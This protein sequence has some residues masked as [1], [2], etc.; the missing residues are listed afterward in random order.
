MCVGGVVGPLLHPL[1]IALYSFERV[2]F[3]SPHH[4]HL[5]EWHGGHLPGQLGHSAL[6]GEHGS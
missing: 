6:F 1:G 3:S 2:G 4:F 5:G